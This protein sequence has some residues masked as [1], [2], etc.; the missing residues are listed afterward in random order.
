M[1]SLKLLPRSTNIQFIQMRYFAFFFSAILILLSITGF[2]HKGIN[3]G[4][5]FTGGVLLE[6][7]IKK[8]MTISSLRQRIDRLKFS[9]VTIQQFGS[10]KDVLIRVGEMGHY[11]DQKQGAVKAS[12]QIVQ[13]IKKELGG[14]VSFQRVEVVGPQVSKELISSALVAVLVAVAMMLVY[15][16]IRFEWQFSVGAVVALIHDVILTI[17]V[18]SW[19][20]LDFTLATVAAVLTIIGYSM[21]DTVVVY[22]RIRENLKKFKK[23]PLQELF[24]TSINETLS[25]TVMTSVT[26]LM[27]L[28]ILYVFGVEVIKNFSFAMIWGVL[29]GTYF[30]NFYCVTSLNIS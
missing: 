30:F 9:D 4:I 7:K 20:Q 27:A 18:F 6:L 12:N 21:N 11:Q 26:T 22:D 15:I 29:I 10:P 5:D 17:G 28:F 3:Y 19:L 23:I 24:T 14:E 13:K 2:M 1:R 16:W 8:N 25:R